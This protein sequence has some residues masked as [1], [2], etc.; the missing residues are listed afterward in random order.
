MYLKQILFDEYGGFSDRRIK[1]LSKGKTFIVDDRNEEDF[2]AGGRLFSTFCM[3][4]ADVTVPDPLR[5]EEVSATL[6]GNVPDSASVRTWADRNGA[7]FTT[8]TLQ[9]SLRFKVTKGEQAKLRSLA[10]AV[11]GI[12]SRSAPRYSVPSY[13]YVCP[14]TASSLERLARVL[15]KAWS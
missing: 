15:E 14:R 6:C 1:R 10:D 2:G 11:R 3:I 13:K 5:G 8:T 12:V 4:F 9:S 7:T